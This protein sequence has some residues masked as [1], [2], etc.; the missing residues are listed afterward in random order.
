MKQTSTPSPL[1]V[2]RMSG[3]LS[4]ADIRKAINDGQI[5]I[6]HLHGGGLVRD[7]TIG[8]ASL[9]L[10][11]SQ[12]YWRWKTFR[13]RSRVLDLALLTEDQLKNLLI[14]SECSD[15]EKGI[16]LAPG[17]FILGRSREKVKIPD[18]ILGLLTGRSS[19][20]RIGVSISCTQSLMAPGHD[21][22]ITL[23]ICNN[24]PYS[25]IIYP[26]IRIAQ[27]MFV[28][29]NQAAKIPYDKNEVAKYIFGPSGDGEDFPV[30]PTW[31]RDEYEKDNKPKT[32]HRTLLQSI[33]WK[34]VFEAIIVVSALFMLGSTVT[35]IMASA[36]VFSNNDAIQSFN[37]VLLIPSAIFLLLSI[38][39][40]TFVRT[41]N[42]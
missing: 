14:K 2:A 41:G 19:Y 39:L 3:A 4:D 36:K 9:D 10:T 22:Y 5:S 6:T 34:S 8:S 32:V 42:K 21:S 24:A 35:A 38:I 33:N 7:V 27:L 30:L 15:K 37:L 40:R 13:F 31:F 26:D 29:L 11:L 20:S 23:Q 18:N 28:S 17:E 12:H 25:I 1:T 16:I